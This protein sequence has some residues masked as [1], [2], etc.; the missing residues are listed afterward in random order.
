MS[1]CDCRTKV[2]EKLLPYNTK[3]EPIFSIDPSGPVR[4]PWP[5]STVQVEKGRGQKKAMALFA[6]YCPFC[7][8]SCSASA[9][10]A[11][12]ATPATEPA[13]ALA[14][15]RESVSLL[16]AVESTEGSFLDRKA[17]CLEK[18]GADMAELIAAGTAMGLLYDGPECTQQENT[19]ASERFKRALISVRGTA[20]LHCPAL[21]SVG[22]V[23]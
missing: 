15:I 13:G 5:I 4:M 23:K 16:R 9:T 19:A 1:T 14:V 8:L 6:S 3:V 18:A 21:A 2:N 22:G 12:A 7:G 11:I 10:A 17:E 20:A